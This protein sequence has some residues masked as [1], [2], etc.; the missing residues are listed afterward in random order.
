[1]RRT[2][3]GRLSLRSRDIAHVQYAKD[4]TEPGA[5][6]TNA[7]V[8]AGHRREAHIQLVGRHG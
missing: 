5:E 1:M 6:G 2:G 3:F 8:S 4:G 7:R